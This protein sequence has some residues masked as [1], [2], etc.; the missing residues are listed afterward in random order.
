MATVVN[1]SA[2]DRPVW[3]ALTSGNGRF[4]EGGSLAL[5]FP[6]D[7]APFA[8]TAE[9]SSEAFAALGALVSRDGRV[10]LVSLDKLK[11]HLGLEVVREAPI[12]QMVALAGFEPLVLGAADVP[13]M[14]DLAER[15]KP[16]PFGPR[17]HELGQYIGIRVD[18]ALAAMAG[19]RM[20]LNGC[21]EIS[22]VC[23]SPEHRGRGYAA[24]LVAWLVHKLRE[25]GA[26][27]FLHVFTDNVPAI[28]LYE[29]LGFTTRKTLR[30]TVFSR[31]AG[32]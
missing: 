23:V 13:E 17:T 32:A 5:R 25:E 29:R 28:A 8:A 12:V 24:L 21:V 18:G 27:P 22:A 30:L 11:P 4:A 1:V 31:A 3:S 20:R 6:A 15:T 9:D 14:L 10:A 16:G 2:L 19:E 26:T 7:I